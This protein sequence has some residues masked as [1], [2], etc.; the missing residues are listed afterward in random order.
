MWSFIINPQAG[1]GRG[2]LQFEKLQKTLDYQ[3]LQVVYY[4]SE[5]E[6]HAEAIVRELAAN[7]E[8]RAIMVI[9]GD[10]TIHEVINGIG[11]CDIP[12]G[13]VPG[14]S[15]NDFARGAHIKGRPEKILAPLTD[16][17]MQFNN[18]IEITD[19]FAGG[20]GDTSL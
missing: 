17:E 9:G 2:K 8:I 12:V 10:G 5:Y 16:V 11:S 14:G 19:L 7:E 18:R 15:G 4:Y 3:S 20:W 6:S 13:F 1:N